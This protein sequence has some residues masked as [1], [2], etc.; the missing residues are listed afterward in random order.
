MVAANHIRRS[1][2]LLVYLGTFSDEFRQ[3]QQL[4]YEISQN[5]K[6]FGHLQNKDLLWQLSKHAQEEPQIFRMIQS[7]AT[8]EFEITNCVG[9]RLGHGVKTANSI[10]GSSR[11]LLVYWDG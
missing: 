6:V 9:A 5:S 2:D 10:I 3:L 4:A 8:R 1:L 7:V 11:S